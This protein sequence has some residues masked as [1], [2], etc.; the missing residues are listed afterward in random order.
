MGHSPNPQVGKPLARKV[1]LI[2][3]HAQRPGESIASGIGIAPIQLLF[4]L[5]NQFQAAL[6][7]FAGEPGGRGFRQ[8][9]LCL[10]SGEGFPLDSHESGGAKHGCK[11]S[12]RGDS[13]SSK[14]AAKGKRR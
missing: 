11:A 12:A 4:G 5:G 3:E 2:L 6:V 8:L 10:L 1:V 7:R 14:P 13:H 9:R